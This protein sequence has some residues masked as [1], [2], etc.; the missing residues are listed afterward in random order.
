MQSLMKRRRAV[1]KG[2]G[3]AMKRQTTGKEINPQ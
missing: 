2:E 3:K 1:K